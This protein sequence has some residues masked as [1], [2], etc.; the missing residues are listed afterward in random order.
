MT[1]ISLCSSLTFA[2]WASPQEADSAMEKLDVE[3]R[4]NKDATSQTKESVVFRIL[5]ETARERWGTLRFSYSPKIQ[6]FR[7]SE[8]GTQNEKDKFTNHF[9]FLSDY[10]T[11]FLFSK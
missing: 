11:W 10:F 9:R 6:K 1:A 7:I 5:K 8:A 3:I 4:V 2:R